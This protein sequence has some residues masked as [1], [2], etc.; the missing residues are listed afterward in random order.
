MNRLPARRLPRGRRAQDGGRSGVDDRAVGRSRVRLRAGWTATGAEARGDALQ[1]PG[2][3]PARSGA[4]AARL[5]GVGRAGRRWSRPGDGPRVRR[6]GARS[7]PRAR[8]RSCA[9]CADGSN[10]SVRQWYL[11]VLSRAT[12]RVW[13]KARMAPRSSAGSS[14]RQAGSGWRA[15]TAKRAL[16]RGRKPS[17]TV[18]ASAMVVAEARRSSVT[19]RSWN[20][21]AMRSTRPLACGERAKIR[22]TP[23]SASAR[24]NWVEACTPRALLVG[25]SG[26]RRGDRCRGRAGCLSG[27]AP[28]RSAGS[29]R[30]AC[31]G[32]RRNS[33]CTTEPVASSTASRRAKRGPRCSSQ[34]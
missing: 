15:A 32:V 20:V 7:R 16:K 26:R 8:R 33:A 5:S 31:L 12:L 34:A 30:G 6:R 17:S 9:C 27:S 21:P 28:A 24:A 23:S 2:R 14:G 18:C 1:L 22:R 29:S 25:G 19:R 3:A 4:R 13:R 11:T 10:S